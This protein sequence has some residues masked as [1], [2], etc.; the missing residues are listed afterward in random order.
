MLAIACIA[1]AGYSLESFKHLAFFKVKNVFI[2][3]GSDIKDD[4]NK[5]FTYLI[6]KNIF[7]LDLKKNAQFIQS[8]YPAYRTARLVR[9]LPNQICVDL[10]KRK[11]VA[12]LSTQPALYLDEN[13]MLFESPSAQ[14]VKCVPLITGIETRS[15]QFRPGTRCNDPG[16]V[17]AVRII[18]QAGR[19]KAL[20]GFNIQKV[21]IRDAGN[22]SLYFPGELEVRVSQDNLKN[23]MQILESLLK[24][25]GNGVANIEYIDLRFKDPVIRFKG[26]E[27]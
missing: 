7:S 5:D 9:F 13:L 1:L 11:P 2:R 18:Q 14:D 17:M 10:M 21:H 15:A 22:A 12:C 19:N 23:T 27:A 16:A 4:R 6:G 8:M 24:Q 25:V 26:K 3:E 20:Q